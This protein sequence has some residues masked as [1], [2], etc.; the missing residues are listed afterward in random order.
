MNRRYLAL[1]AAIVVVAVIGLYVVSRRSDPGGDTAKHDDLIRPKNPEVDP[2]QPKIKVTQTPPGTNR[3]DPR[4]DPSGAGSAVSDYMVG[5]VRIRDHRSGDHAPVDIPPAIHPPQGRKIPSQLTSDIAQKLRAVTTACTASMPVEGRGAQA[6]LDG[7][8]KIAIKNHQAEVTSATFQ[9]RDVA[10]GA[11]SP[12]KQ[13]MEQ[14]SVGVTT[15]AGDEPDVEGYS[16]SLS[17]R[18]P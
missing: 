13:C 12:V 6:R 3:T 2:G 18:V 7:E 11:D 15:P 9:L 17:L 4:P 10:G 5:G 14:K 8:I 16:I 1:G